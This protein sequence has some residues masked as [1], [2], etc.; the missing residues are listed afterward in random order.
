MK[1]KLWKYKGYIIHGAAV[2]IIFLDPSVRHYLTEHAA[3]S[4]TGLLVEGWLLHW[5]QGQ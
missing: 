4:G 1:E 2:L 3:Y 5:A